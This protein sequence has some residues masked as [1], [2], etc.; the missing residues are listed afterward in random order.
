MPGSSLM[1]LSIKR[2]LGLDF[3]DRA[4]DAEEKNSLILRE[5]GLV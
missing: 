3:A 2:E 1:N 4:T 5:L